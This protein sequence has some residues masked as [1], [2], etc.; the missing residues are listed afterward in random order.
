MFNK[1]ISG[2]LMFSLV[3]GF[4]FSIPDISRVSILALKKPG[5]SRPG[6]PHFNPGPTQIPGPF[7]PSLTPPHCSPGPNEPLGPHMQPGPWQEPGP[8]FL[9]PASLFRSSAPLRLQN[10]NH[11]EGGCAELPPDEEPP[12]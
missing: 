7:P 6:G 12:S 8:H 9:P 4:F 2:I 5:P 3:F 11:F 10:F 1:T